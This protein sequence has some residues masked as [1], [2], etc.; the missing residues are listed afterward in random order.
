MCEVASRLFQKKGLAE[1][2]EHLPKGDEFENAF[3]KK[4]R[5]FHAQSQR[6]AILQRG[7]HRQKAEIRTVW[8]IKKQQTA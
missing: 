6:K 1:T 4:G 3:Q 2:K 8:Y 7:H 5:K